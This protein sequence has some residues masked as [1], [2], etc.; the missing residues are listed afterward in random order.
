DDD[1]YSPLD[2][3]RRLVDR[4]VG[5]AVVSRT[6]EPGLLVTADDVL[7]FAVPAVTAVDHRSAGDSMT[8][9]IAVGVGRGLSVIDSVR[10]GADAGA[11]NVPRRELGTG[12][13]EQIERFSDQVQVRV[14]DAD[15]VVSSMEAP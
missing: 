9:G 13:G 6:A 10:L 15:R 1:T 3:A 2:A 7:E 11:L 12:R 5:A 14:F 8:G 4:G